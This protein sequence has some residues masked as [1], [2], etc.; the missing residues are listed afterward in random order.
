MHAAS[1]LRHMHV[2][3]KNWLPNKRDCFH[4]SHSPSPNLLYYLTKRISNKPFVW[5]YVKPAESRSPSSA[6][7]IWRHELI[8][9]WV[10]SKRH[11]DMSRQGLRVGWAL[12]G[13]WLHWLITGHQG[14]ILPPALETNLE[15][16]GPG[17]K[18][19]AIIA[20]KSCALRG[21]LQRWCSHL[22]A[23]RTSQLV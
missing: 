17:W 23:L 5:E 1:F 7:G 13:C 9:I 8:I 21:H 15:L 4:C 3:L 14:C 20:N 11:P 22:Q 10:C 12:C 18:V 19:P 6:F 2:L 16:L